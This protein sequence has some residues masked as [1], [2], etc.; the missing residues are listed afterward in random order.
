VRK[1]ALTKATNDRLLVVREGM[2]SLITSTK[3]VGSNS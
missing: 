2:M 1:R 3:K